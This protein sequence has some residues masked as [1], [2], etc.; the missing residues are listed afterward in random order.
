MDDGLDDILDQQREGID[1]LFP[2]L[3]RQGNSS[4]SVENRNSNN[5]THYVESIIIQN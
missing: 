1:E 5:S 2:S 4:S 3:M